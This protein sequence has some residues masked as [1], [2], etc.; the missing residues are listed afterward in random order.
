MNK[1][2]AVVILFSS[3]MINL[4]AQEMRDSIEEIVIT[5]SKIERPIRQTA[6]PVEVIPQSTVAKYIGKTLDQLLEDQVGVSINGGNSNPAA[7]KNIYVRGA[8]PGYTLILI[9]GL[10]ASDASAI[11]ST[12]DFR[13]LDINQIERIEIAKG[14]QSTLYG[15]DAIAGVINIITK[16]GNTEPFKVNANVTYGN[17]ETVESGVSINGTTGGLNYNIGHQISSSDGISEAFDRTGDNNFD[18]DGHDKKVTYAKINY[19]INEKWNISPSAQH[20]TFEGDYDAGS[21]TDGTDNYESELLNLGI[22]S[23]M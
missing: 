13:L 6:R 14:S 22:K 5:D 8:A 20:S 18:N 23:T 10:P 7:I 2:I 16:K 21:F 3:C 11:G 17:Y 15:S 1:L 4:T 12:L 19:S 9:D